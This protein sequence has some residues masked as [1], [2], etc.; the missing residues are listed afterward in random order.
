MTN[1]KP[2]TVQQQVFKIPEYQLMR[3]DMSQFKLV[4]LVY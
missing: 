4:V 2:P 1:F 3:F